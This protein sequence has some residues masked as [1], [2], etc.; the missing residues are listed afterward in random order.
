MVRLLRPAVGSGEQ[1]RVVEQVAAWRQP[2]IGV[3][4]EDAVANRTD[5]LHDCVLGLLLRLLFYGYCNLNVFFTV[6]YTLY[7]YR[8]KWNVFIIYIIDLLDM[9]NEQNRF[10]GLTRSSTRSQLLFTSYSQ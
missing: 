9:S 1:A 5:G 7:I 6:L 4:V 10:I 2:N 3:R 8:C